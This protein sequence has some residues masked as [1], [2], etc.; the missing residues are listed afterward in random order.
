MEAVPRRVAWTGR[1]SG[2]AVSRPLGGAHFPILIPILIDLL[3][4]L[5]IRV[6]YRHPVAESA[7]KGALALGEGI[8][9]RL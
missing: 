7:D 1:G 9:A 6:L 3:A 8:L 4:A 2:R 5:S